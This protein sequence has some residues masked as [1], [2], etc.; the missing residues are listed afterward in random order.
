V[1][2]LKLPHLASQAAKQWTAGFNPRP[3]QEEDLLELYQ[4]AY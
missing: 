3:V 4:R 1:D 2:P